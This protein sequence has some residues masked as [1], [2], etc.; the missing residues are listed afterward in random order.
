MLSSTV[1]DVTNILYALPNLQ[2]KVAPARKR[3]LLWTADFGQK[4]EENVL[5]TMKYEITD[6]GGYVHVSRAYRWP[7]F[8]CENLMQSRSALTD[9]FKYAP[10]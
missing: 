10:I 4:A 3:A 6:L 8:D 5:A 7:A 9:G 2:A 1:K